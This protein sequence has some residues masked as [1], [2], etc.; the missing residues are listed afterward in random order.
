MYTHTQADPLTKHSHRQGHT[1]IYTGLHTHISAHT[2]SC[3]YGGS[4]TGNTLTQ[5]WGLHP[6]HLD[7]NGHHV[8]FR[9][10]VQQAKGGT[11]VL[12]LAVELN[13]GDALQDA[14]VCQVNVPLLEGSRDE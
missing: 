6:K 10:K 7:G 8:P 1:S 2:H 5:Q 4:H 12:L 13:S 14:V 3:P 9:V 11:L